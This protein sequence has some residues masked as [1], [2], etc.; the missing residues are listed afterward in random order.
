MHGMNNTKFGASCLSDTTRVCMPKNTISSTFLTYA[1]QKI[2]VN[3][4]TVNQTAL[5]RPMGK[6]EYQ[7]VLWYQP[8]HKIVGV[9]TWCSEVVRRIWRSQDHALQYISIANQPDAPVYQIS[10]FWNYILRVSDGLSIHRQEFKTVHT[11]TGVCQTDTAVCLLAG[12]LASRQQYLFDICL[13]LYV[14]SWTPDDGWK[15]RSKRVELFQNKI[16]W[17]N[18]ASSWFYY[19]NCQLK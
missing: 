19:T 5:R 8:S 11:A 15:D 9:K 6:W 18:G 7:L 10:L 12:T 16:I 4:N 1:E 13:L 14:Q 2:N 3:C 17:N